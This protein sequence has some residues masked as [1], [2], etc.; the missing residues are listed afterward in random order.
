MAFAPATVQKNINMGILETVYL[1][2]PPNEEVKRIVA[3]VDE[4]M[5][6]CDQ[7]KAKLTQSQEQSEKLIDAMFRQSLVA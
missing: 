5:A 4:L 2:L 1:P 6:L 3:K 7:L